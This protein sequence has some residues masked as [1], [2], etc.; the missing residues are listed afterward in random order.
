MKLNRN[1][2]TRP[3]ERGRHL[4]R[5]L[6]LL[7]LLVMA[8][9]LLAPRANAASIVINGV[10]GGGIPG[11][12]SSASGS[13]AIYQTTATVGFRFT[14]VDASGKTKGMPYDIYEDSTLASVLWVTS[15]NGANA[16]SLHTVVKNENTE[17]RYTKM[18]YAG[19]YLAEPTLPTIEMTSTS[20]LGTYGRLDS[21]L[22]LSLPTNAAAM[23]AWPNI[24]F[25]PNLVEA[26]WN[27]NLTDMYNNGYSIAIE[28]LYPAKIGGA[29]FCATVTEYA[30]MAAS[31]GT[32][33]SGTP[34]WTAQ[35]INS[36]NANSF[37]FLTNYTHCHWPSALKLEKAAWGIPVPSRTLAA[38]SGNR[39]TAQEIITQGYGIMQVSPMDLAKYNNTIAHYAGGF[40][41]GEG[42]S[43]GKD[44]FLM[45]NTSIPGYAAGNQF[46]MTPAFATSIPNGLYLKPQFP[47]SDISG[48]WTYYDMGTTVTQAAKNMYFEYLYLPQAYSI[49]YN[50]NGGTNSTNNP[51][52]YNVYY[53]IT[54]IRTNWSCCEVL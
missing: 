7:L 16:K 22:G 37:A 19:I 44:W 31:H 39:G 10:P 27:T 29:W 13:Y 3:A 40:T 23:A 43:S 15:N 46:T 24:S 52:G 54:L 6:C 51:S 20:D 50:L 30:I 48:T 49:T 26:L 8:V 42:N 18:E 34:S 1:Y 45:G 14:L 33:Y 28:P 36:S 11:A 21:A 35:V 9:P 32:A 12:T 47:T 5:L 53:G 38:S 41:N 25:M 17:I 2:N 4:T